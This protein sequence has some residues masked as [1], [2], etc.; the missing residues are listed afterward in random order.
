MENWAV[1]THTC[2]STLNRAII[3]ASTGVTKKLHYK[4]ILGKLKIEQMDEIN[5]KRLQR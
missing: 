5:W 4:I 2:H 1:K 3:H